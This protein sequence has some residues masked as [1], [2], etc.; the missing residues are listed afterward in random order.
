MKHPQAWHRRAAAGLAG[1]GMLLGAAACTSAEPGGEG[2]SSASAPPAT[3]AALEPVPFEVPATF[4]DGAAWTAPVASTL[5]APGGAGVLAITAGD[6]DE[7]RLAMLDSDSGAIVWESTPLPEGTHSAA[8]WVLQDGRPWAVFVTRTADTEVTLLAFDANRSGPGVAPTS[9]TSVTGA[10]KAPRVTL[11]LH[12]VLV[13]GAAS[14]ASLWWP[15]SGALTQYGQGPEREGVAGSPVAAVG[16]AFV[17]VFRAGGFALASSRGGWDSERVAPEG[18]ATA[19]GVVLDVAGGVLVAV[20]P[21]EKAPD[22]R[23]WVAVHDLWT[24]RVLAA[25]SWDVPLDEARAAA[26]RAVPSEDGRWVAWGPVV[27]DLHDEDGEGD[28]LDLDGARPVSIARGVLYAQPG[29]GE[30]EGST[31][32]E[33]T[34]IDLL[35]GKEIAA[36]DEMPGAFTA[37]GLGLFLP[38]QGGTT[39]ILAVPQH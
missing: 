11:D 25:R 1:M 18:A 33:P 16:D 4:Q 31:A 35:T 5:V 12:G 13:S 37:S 14:G 36:G 32:G 39:T 20:W 34:A 3:A 2:A 30:E 29:P 26:S 9:T 8:G 23:S 24:G 15:A 28:T 6:G 19:G 7:R 17:V 22:K 27:L 21:D 38:S 10:D